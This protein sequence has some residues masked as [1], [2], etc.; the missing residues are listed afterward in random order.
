MDEPAKAEALVLLKAT[1]PGDWR[2]LVYG[3][4]AILGFRL[5]GSLFF[6]EALRATGHGYLP[7]TVTFGLFGERIMLASDV[8]LAVALSKARAKLCTEIV[9]LNSMLEVPDVG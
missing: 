5:S 6:V 9:G 2:P 1:W 4:D 8:A 3:G 7:W